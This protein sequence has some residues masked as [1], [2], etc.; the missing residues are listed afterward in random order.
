MESASIGGYLLMGPGADFKEVSLINA[1]VGGTLN[2]TGAKVTGTLNMNGANI[3]GSLLMRNGAEFA[4][5]IL[6]SAHVGG[7][8]DLDCAKVTGTL[9]MDSAAIGSDLFMRAGQYSKPINLVFAEVGG[10]LDLRGSTLAGLDLTGM[11]ID[12][13]L[14]LASGGVMPTSCSTGS[15]AAIVWGD[16]ATLILRNAQAGV[17]QDEPEANVWPQQTDLNGFTYKRLGGFAASPE[18]AVE[19][20]GPQWFRDWLARGEPYTPQPYQQASN[21]LREMGHPEMANDV[22][23]AGR[24]R[25]RSEAWE[26]GDNLRW[27]GLSLLNWTMGYGIGHRYFWSLRWVVGLVLVATIVLGVTGQNTPP[28]WGEK[29]IGIWYSFDMLLPI[30]ELRK[31]H[32]DVDLK[33]FA[34]YWF[35]FH[36]LM[37]Y[38]L[39][40]FLIAG[41]AGLTS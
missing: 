11:R 23:Y 35:Y 22:L 38:V 9:D 10:N 15:G 12:G 25:E 4:D 31:A 26:R 2:L 17:L 7:Q 41:L 40:S 3:D 33:G 21:V 5:G 39:A 36:K 13:E 27:L 18:A 1:H 30:I 24:E 32:Y 29:R 19:Q 14:S 16:G 28:R 37:G 20:R 6:L 8:L 34:R